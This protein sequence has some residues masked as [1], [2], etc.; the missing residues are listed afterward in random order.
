MTAL[1]ES[2]A[3]AIPEGWVL[4]D[5]P[6]WGKDGRELHGMGTKPDA[7]VPVTSWCV[8]YEDLVFLRKCVNKAIAD[9]AIY[10]TDR[11][12]F[13]KESEDI[14]PNMYTV[15]EQYIKPLTKRAGS[16]SWAL[17]RNPDGLPCDLFITHGWIE[18]IFEFID[19]VL[20][21]WPRGKK[22]CY[23]CVLS[24]PQNLDISS[25]ISSP[26]TSPFAMCLTS[27]SHMLVV[28]NHYVS[29]YSRLWCVYEAFLAYKLDKVIVTARP[30]M[31]LT[32]SKHMC[33]LA[34][35]LVVGCSMA[36][37]LH[38][39]CLLTSDL[40]WLLVVAVGVALL[41]KVVKRIDFPGRLRLRFPVLYLLSLGGVGL[42]GYAVVAVVK[43][44]VDGCEAEWMNYGTLGLSFTLLG[45]FVG[46]EVDRIRTC[47]FSQQAQL[48]K[49]G[50]T[51]VSAAGC[52]NGDDAKRI[53]TEI[54]SEL[55]HVDDAVLVLR[56]A[57]MSTRR[58]RA[59]HARGVDVASA[60]TISASNFC[61]IV[62]FWLTW[63]MMFLALPELQ[64]GFIISWIAVNFLV[65]VGSLV[66]YVRAVR[67]QRAFAVAVTAKVF[68]ISAILLRFLT[69]E[70]EL[71]FDLPVLFGVLI[72]VCTLLSVVL[73]RLGM[74]GVAKLPY[75]GPELAAILGPQCAC[76][77]CRRALTE[78]EAKQEP[79]SI[80]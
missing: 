27:A 49:K 59:A 62:G 67:D 29:I 23:V 34:L 26:S 2:N 10:P 42:S 77:C 51:S 57:G 21:S 15:C 37:G 8:T 44:F 47:Q 16:M 46:C 22:A 17:M 76:M 20:N 31:G 58:L 41:T 33:I 70:D 9:G 71:F 79:A 65:A 12:Q 45:F 73:S 28:P 75:V 43:E 55:A 5:A 66:W 6:G 69:R 48:L 61:Y 13:D 63:Q 19:K 36:A 72:S 80:S 25:L 11:D 56:A 35:P 14:G 78:P 74:H 60:G 18:G 53:Q 39:D 64:L 1:A 40:D 4:E 68:L 30:P 3:D 24:N 54:H 52:S 7:G 32:L 50:F 38:Y